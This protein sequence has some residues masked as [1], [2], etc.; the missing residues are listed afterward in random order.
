MKTILL[1]IISFY[2]ITASLAQDAEKIY[3]KTVGSVGLI[4]D[5]NGFGSGFFVNNNTFITNR[6]VSVNVSLQNTEI[7]LKNG[8]IIKPLKLILE[9]KNSDLAAYRTE[10]V[11]EYLHLAN[12]TSTNNGDKI[13]AIGNPASSVNIYKFSITEGIINNITHEEISVE[14]FPISA[15]IILHSATL[16]KGNSGGPLINNKGE[17]VGINS[18]IHL[19]GNNQFV[20]IH[21]S[22]LISLL[23]KYSIDYNSKSLAEDRNDTV[24]YQDKKELFPRKD[25]SQVNI[26]PKS[27]NDTNKT[28]KLTYTANDNTVIIIFITIGS[29]FLLIVFAISSNNKKQNK[30]I[31]QQ[32]QKWQSSESSKI[33][34]ISSSRYAE[35]SRKINIR[36]ALII[37]GQKYQINKSE[38]YAGKSI[39][40]DFIINGDPFVSKQHFKIIS[41]GGFFY[42]TDLSSKN[43]TYVN[44]NRIHTSILDNNDIIR[45]GNSELIFQKYNQI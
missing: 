34:P 22:E 24:K 40:C 32:S 39:E 23:K 17:V 5:M 21:V 3:E 35:L 25:T 26:P 14:E 45:V 37:N 29:V 38:V 33:N 28:T 10:T 20:A 16:N 2:Y 19:T 9:D 15:Q 6:H 1:I 13:Y 41:A 18:Y 8:S 30:I 12:E 43:G 42:I 11:R 27:K 7:R 4:T 36:G 31:N 44:G